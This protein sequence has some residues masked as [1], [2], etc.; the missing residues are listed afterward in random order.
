MAA[1]T[2]ES[3]T[4]KGTQPRLNLTRH[5]LRSTASPR[6][7]RVH[8]PTGTGLTHSETTESSEALA[9]ALSMC[10]MLR[11]LYASWRVLCVC[12]PRGSMC[13]H[14]SESP[15][16][17]RERLRRWVS[18]NSPK[19]PRL[20]IQFLH[21]V[22]NIQHFWNKLAKSNVFMRSPA[23]RMPSRAKRAVQAAYYRQ[24]VI[25]DICIAIR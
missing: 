8:C 12:S 15:S 21:C 19:F 5:A 24:R 11:R 1:D 9:R 10:A 25:A 6:L 18:G 3:T 20:T 7:F 2:F 23:R 22:V 16:H 14:G 13:G 17:L 4:L